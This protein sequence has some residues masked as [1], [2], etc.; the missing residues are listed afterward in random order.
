MLR[1]GATATVTS[2]FHLAAGSVEVIGVLEEPSGSFTWTGG[3]LG[4][5]ESRPR[6][7]YL[8]RNDIEHW[9][10]KVNSTR[11][12]GF[13]ERFN[14]TALD[15]F[16]RPAFRRRFYESV[17]ALQKDLDKWLQYYNLKRAHE[18]YRNRGA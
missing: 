9:R 10:T 8:T 6:E 14:R 17:G 2:D 1:H 13:V 5:T 15:K 16:F 3:A 7:L 18:G 12:N 4:D 11:T